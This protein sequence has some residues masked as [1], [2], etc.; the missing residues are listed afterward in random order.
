MLDF[1]KEKSQITQ[2]S[3]RMMSETV[4]QIINTIIFAYVP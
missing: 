2:Q 1:W 3:L 4:R